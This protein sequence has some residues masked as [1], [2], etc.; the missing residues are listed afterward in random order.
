MAREDMLRTAINSATMPIYATQKADIVEYYQEKYGKN[1]T[2]QAALDLSGAP[3]GSTAYKSA[4]RHF[5]GSRLNAQPK[6]AKAQAAAAERYKTLGE[7]LPPIGRTLKPGRDS[8]TVT[9]RGT[10]DNG[11]P[12]GRE[13]KIKVSFSGSNA[14]QFINDPDFLSIWDAYDV[15]PGTFDDG[16]YEI[17][18]SG[19]SAA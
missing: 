6:T 9:V 13:R 7:K 10:Q 16:E 15:D 12:Q 2:V 1:W 17:D 11:R 4:Q 14:T 18:V 19:V 8:I 5:Q 3:K